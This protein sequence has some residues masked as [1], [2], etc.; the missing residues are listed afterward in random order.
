MFLTFDYQFTNYSSPYLPSSAG[1]GTFNIEIATNFGTVYT[2]IGTINLDG[3]AGWRTF[4][5]DLSSYAGQTIKIKISGVR[6]SGDWDAAF[7]NFKIDY[8]LLCSIT[9]TW[10]GSVWNPSTPVANQIA[11]INGNYT[12]AGFQACE[13]NVLGTSVVSITSGILDISGIV[14][15]D[16]GASLSLENNVNLVQEQNVTNVGNIT[17]KRNSTPMIRLD[18]TAWSSPVMGQNLLNFSPNT[19][20]TRFYTY[21]EG[22]TSIPTAWVSVTDPANTNFV[23]G[24]GYLIRVDNYWSSTIASI[25][26]GIFPGI[27]NNGDYS[28]PVSFTGS[29]FN[30]IGNPYPST[31]DAFTFVN[32]NNVLNNPSVGIDALYFWTHATPATGGSYSVNNYASYTSGAGGV[33]AAGG[34]PQPNGEIQIGQGFIVHANGAGNVLFNNGQRLTVNNGQFFRNVLPLIERHRVWLNLNDATHNY[35]QILVGYIE[36]ATETVD[37]GIDARL[38]STSQTNLYSLINDEKYVIQGRTLPFDV[39]D[40]VPLGITIENEGNYTI[41]LDHFDSFFENQDVYIWDK[42]VNVIHNLKSSS[43]TFSSQAGVFDS[44]FSLVYTNEMLSLE[45]PFSNLDAI[46][47]VQNGEI[48][49]T[50]GSELMKDVVVYDI[51]GRKL[52]TQTA[53]NSSHFTISKKLVTNQIVLIEIRTPK[54]VILRE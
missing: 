38:F 33:A 40:E 6:T 25:F 5:Y 37:S 16:P 34:G 10:D 15:V 30:L 54:G 26:P 2:P 8:P 51:S 52:L 45:N 42:R 53:I 7:D 27:P 29:G 46:V 50:T 9:H 21:N 18:Y 20:L 43:Y 28:I 19:I 1:A 31:I 22:G 11:T 49:I 3:I 41:T 36:S 17:V 23:E 32:E 44:R 39:N 48:V 35:N 13:L 14:R 4:T 47:Y 24:V 12:G